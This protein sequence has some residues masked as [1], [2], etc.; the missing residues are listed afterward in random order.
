[1]EEILKSLFERG[2]EVNLGRHSC[3]DNYF[4]VIGEIDSTFETDWDGA[5][6][7]ATPL[8]ALM[9]ALKLEGLQTVIIVEETP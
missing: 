7:G 5:G 9:D 6:H 1:M 8:L 4:C 3:D 2:L